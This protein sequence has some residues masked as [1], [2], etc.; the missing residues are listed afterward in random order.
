MI[1]SFFPHLNLALVPDPE[2]LV[3]CS[4]EDITPIFFDHQVAAGMS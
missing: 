1:P 4:V 2:I 3:L